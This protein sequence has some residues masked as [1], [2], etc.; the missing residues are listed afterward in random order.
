MFC[1]VFIY[2][3]HFSYC[4]L[5]YFL[6]DGDYSA[7]A[8]L[9]IFFSITTEMVGPRAYSAAALTQ[10]AMKCEQRY[11]KRFRKREMKHMKLIFFIFLYTEAVQLRSQCK[12]LKAFDSRA[13]GSVALLGTTQS[14]SGSLHRASCPAGLSSVEDRKRID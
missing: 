10:P 11:F 3:T 8:S 13:K 14:F 7:S 12:T 9:K 5:S 6:R 4:I 1:R 2:S